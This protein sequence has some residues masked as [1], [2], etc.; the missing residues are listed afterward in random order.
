MVIPFD[1]FFRR[2]A[3]STDIATQM[4]LARALGVNRSAITQAKLRDAVPSKWILALSRRYGISPDWLEFGTK[5]PEHQRTPQREQRPPLAL[6]DVSLETV[7]VPKVRATLC[8]GGGSLEL[9]AVPVSEHPLPRAWLS[10]MGQPNAMVFMDVIG[11]SMEPG[12][13]DGDMVLVDQSRT[14]MAAKTVLAVGYEDAIFIKRLE[15]RSNGLAM[16]SDN[17]EYGPVEIAGDELASFRVIGKVVWLCRDC[18]YA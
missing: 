14:E 5:A 7:L 6:P 2:V 16:L 13:R 8:A 18:R 12:I 17:P 3:E 9:E 11:N 15:K 10:R 4:D 1:A